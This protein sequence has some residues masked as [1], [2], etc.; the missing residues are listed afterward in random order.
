KQVQKCIIHGKEYDSSYCIAYKIQ[1]TYEK[2]SCNNDCLL[3]WNT[4]YQQACSTRCSDGY[5]RVIYECTKTSLLD[6][7]MESLDENVC[8]RYVGEKPADV[9]SCVGD[10]T[11]TGWVYGSWGECHY[12][13]GCVRKRVADCRNASNLSTSPHYCVSDFIYNTE[14]CAEASC[15]QSRWNY[16]VWSNCDCVA[17]QR[18][19]IVTC[20]RN[21]KQ[22]N[23]HECQH[24]PKPDETVSCSDECP[25]SA[26]WQAQPWQP[27]TA[28]CSSQ[29]GIRR[30]QILCTHYGTI[31][32][33][34]YCDPR[35]KP[36]E[37]EWC[38]SNV[39]CTAWLTSEWS[40]CSVTCGK[41]VQRRA[42]ICHQDGRPMDH[43]KCPQPTPSEQQTCHAPDSNLCSTLRWSSGPWSDCS[44]T[45]GTGIQQRNVYCHDSSRPS[46]LIPDIECLTML[47]DKTKPN[48]R[49]TCVINE[50]PQWQTSSWSKCSG[51]CGSA[52]RHRH[53]WCSYNGQEV[54][55]SHCTNLNHKPLPTETCHIDLYCPEWT[56]GMWSECSAPMCSTGM[57]YRQVVCRQG[58]DI[59]SN[60][61]CDESSRPLELQAC[62]TYNSTI[63]SVIRPLSSLQSASSYIW[64]VKQFG[65]CSATCGIGRRLRQVHCIDSQTKISYDDQ[66]CAQ[67]PIKPIEYETCNLDPCPTWQTDPWS[68][69]PVTC[70]SGTQHRTVTCKHREEVVSPEKCNGLNRP[71]ATMQCHAI[72]CPLGTSYTNHFSPSAATWIPNEW[73]Q[74]DRQTCQ[75]TRTVRCIDTMNARIMPPWNCTKDQLQPPSSRACRI[76]ACIEW[77]VARWNSCSVKCGRGF[78][79]GFGLSCFTRQ[80]PIRE[81]N[82]S[83]C[84]LAEPPLP[85]PLTRRECRRSCVEWRTSDWSECDAQCGTGKR[86]R[87]VTCNRK[88]NGQHVPD[89]MCL[90]KR[91]N[92]TRP[93]SEEICTKASCYKWI[94]TEYWTRC[95]V[96]CNGG[97]EENIYRC[98]YTANSTEQIVHDQLCNGV[99]RPQ[100]RRSCNV[101]PCSSISYNVTRRRGRRRRW[102][103]S[104]WSQCNVPC[105]V[106]EQY[107]SVR[108]FAIFR[109]RTIP[110]RF[111]RH[112]SQPNRV[113]QCFQ[114]VCSPTWTTHPWSLCTSTCGAGIEYRGISCHEV[115]NN[116]Y[117]LKN[118]YSNKCDPYRAPTTRISCN[119]GDCESPYLW[120]VEPWSKC[121]SDCNRGEQT[122]RVYCKNR[123]SSQPVN[124]LFCTPHK[125]VTRI[126]CYGFLFDYNQS[127]KR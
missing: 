45:C 88:L 77:R 85:T 95:S 94:S 3:S 10:C 5:K 92:L 120:H 106:G 82:S 66:Y 114:V 18:H 108:C 117:L 54:E 109:N 100:I 25:V 44:V 14:R 27:C 69:C 126:D 1:Y 53:V 89:H 38:S 22:V 86:F 118:N 103:V 15:D 11:G 110:D 20:V 101:Q 115:N 61:N 59:I 121:S 29:Q 4:R 36:N 6:R 49:Q 37:Q 16:T 112:L 9:V 83:E 67:L 124:D 57:Q 123:Q 116:G 111:C 33:D 72:P 105:G 102:E 65:E 104:P 93:I 63:C 21:G 125:P 60:M 122:R 42:I 127:T 113:Q 34:G 13:G 41:G 2:E 19:R 47:G 51:K 12:D 52:V 90:Q 97:F 96:T 23:D 79:Y 26:Q 76:A 58:D 80:M 7:T 28:T 48:E 107:R 32:Q 87:Q 91:R 30:R 73:G 35:L 43:S 74:C 40:P 62:Y 46:S 70:G 99:I 24:E 119:M 55:N 50:C 84:E 64:D 75:Q 68:S 56:S 31:V 98:V 39:T 17:N 81:I 71:A 78:Q 8:R